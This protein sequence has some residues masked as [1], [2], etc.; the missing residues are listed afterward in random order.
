MK[1]SKKEEI[2]QNNQ[3]DDTIGKCVVCGKEFQR[4]PYS[5]LF[6]FLVNNTNTPICSKECKENYDT[7]RT[8]I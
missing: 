8:K 6:E 2:L 3:K 4:D 7:S 1:K 5:M